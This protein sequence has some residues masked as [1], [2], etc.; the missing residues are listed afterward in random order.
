MEVHSLAERPQVHSS[1]DGLV[2]HVDPSRREPRHRSAPL[3]GAGA[4]RPRGGFPRDAVPADRLVPQRRSL[5]RVR[6]FPSFPG[7]PRPPNRLRRLGS[8]T[9]DP[10]LLEPRHAQR[11]GAGTPVACR[12]LGGDLAAPVPLAVNTQKVVDPM[13][14]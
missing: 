4:R 9:G 13:K 10:Q 5:G 12:G 7:V 3:A 2:Q 1:L 8:A 11:V 14:G 6:H